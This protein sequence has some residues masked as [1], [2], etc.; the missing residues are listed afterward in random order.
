MTWHLEGRIKR[1]LDDEENPLVDLERML[2][3]DERAV[4]TEVS[5]LSFESAMGR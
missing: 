5:R 2:A 4:L 3:V 1:K